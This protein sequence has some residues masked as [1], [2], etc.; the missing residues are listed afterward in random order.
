MVWRFVDMHCHLDRMSNAEE[1]AR[2]AAARGIAIFDTPVTP[3]DTLAA[4][5][6]LGTQANV[7]V[8][9]GLHPWWLADGRCSAADVDLA[10]KLAGE[11][12]YIGEVGLDFGRRGGNTQE[13]QAAAFEGICRA[14]AKHPLPHRVISVHAIHAATVALDILERTGAAGANAYPTAVIF[15]WFSGSFEEFGRARRLGCYFSVS[16]HMLKSKRGREYARQLPEG[17]LLLETDAPPGLDAPYS[18]DALEASLTRAL[19]A[20]AE[21]RGTSQEALGSIIAA[22]S[23]SLLNLS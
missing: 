22:T 13:L 18:A 16:E 12:A 9:A 15:H 21:I 7:R 5:E 4:Q 8:G 20:I 2:D 17:R 23:A 11:L 3:A 10:A 1:V 6:R 14:I 19:A